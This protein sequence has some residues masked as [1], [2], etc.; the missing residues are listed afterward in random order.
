[1]KL[2]CSVELEFDMSTRMLL[3]ALVE[4]YP[5]NQNMVIISHDASYLMPGRRYIIEVSFEETGA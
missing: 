4:H 5:L 3:L 2:F 1:M